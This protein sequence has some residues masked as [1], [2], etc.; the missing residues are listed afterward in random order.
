MNP[1]VGFFMSLIIRPGRGDQVPLCV[2][3]THLNLNHLLSR[4]RD[5]MEESVNFS[6]SECQSYIPQPTGLRKQLISISSEY[7]CGTCLQFWW[8][9]LYCMWKKKTLVVS[10]IL[11]MYIS[12]NVRL[13]LHAGL[14][15]SQ[16]RYP[17]DR[18]LWGV[19]SVRKG[20]RTGQSFPLHIL[21]DKILLSREPHNTGSGYVIFMGSFIGSHTHNLRTYYCAV[22][23]PE[24]WSDIYTKREKYTIQTDKS[25][26]KLTG[27]IFRVICLLFVGKHTPCLSC[28][29]SSSVVFFSSLSSSPA[30]SI[31]PVSSCFPVSIMFG[32]SAPGSA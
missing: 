15:T 10:K 7:V 26:C 19:E 3:V 1:T 11:Q 18:L 2:Q 5:F 8:T 31:P 20:G 4:Q 16:I 23:P 14:L 32:K 30:P 12:K 27:I 24:I 21:S 17:G 9:K 28:F 25:F 22:V 6:F 13:P 29:S